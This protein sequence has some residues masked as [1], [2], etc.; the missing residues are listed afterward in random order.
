MTAFELFNVFK[1]YDIPNNAVLV[2]N[3]GWEGGETDMDGIYYNKTRN[4]IVFTQEFSKYDDYYNLP[5]WIKC[6]K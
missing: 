6:R 3:S 2:S 4:V 1:Q 5:D